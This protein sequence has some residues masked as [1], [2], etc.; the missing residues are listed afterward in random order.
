MSDASGPLESTTRVVGIILSME[1]LVIICARLDDVFMA[2][3]FVCCVVGTMMAD[4]V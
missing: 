2:C 1:V 3:A 4:A